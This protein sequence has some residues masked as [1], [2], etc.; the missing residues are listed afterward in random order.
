MA[1]LREVQLREGVLEEVIT[2]N[3]PQNI[4]ALLGYSRG[5]IA[6]ESCEQCLASLKPFAYCV[7][8]G[9]FQGSCSSCHYNS[10]G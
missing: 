1:R 6:E 3:R 8:G 5:D 2:T 4:E 9:L 7:V 10:T